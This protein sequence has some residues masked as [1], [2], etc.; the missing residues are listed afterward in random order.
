MKV[1]DL[2]L[3]V[4]GAIALGLLLAISGASAQTEESGNGQDAASESPQVTKA[5][6]RL[7]RLAAELENRRRKLIGNLRPL[8]AS[9]RTATAPPTLPRSAVPPQAASGIPSGTPLSAPANPSQAGISQ[10]APRC[11]TRELLAKDTRELLAK[12]TRELLAKKVE[13]HLRSNKEHGRL[14]NRVNEKLVRYRRRVL[15]IERVCKERLQ[16]DIESDIARL[17][18][19]DLETERQTVRGFVVCFDVLGKATEKEASAT[20]STIRI[21]RLVAEKARLDELS[22]RALGLER[23]VE[24]G[25]SKRKRLMQELTEFQR[26]IQSACS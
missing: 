14:I 3:I 9:G 23:A 24:R 4:R 10:D 15:D 1:F 22:Q 26:E 11:D 20:R 25:V 19:L 2:T 16:R 5:F 12:D 7:D 6:R 13:T 18:R 17:E 21:Q 8:F